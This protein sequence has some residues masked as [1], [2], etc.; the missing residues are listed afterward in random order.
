MIHS[1]L[2]YTAD[3]L[4]TWWISFDQQSGSGTIIQDSN[5]DLN[6]GGT[7]NIFATMVM[8]IQTQPAPITYKY[9]PYGGFLLQSVLYCSLRTVAAAVLVAP[10]TDYIEIDY[11]YAQ[12]SHL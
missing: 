12:R 11:S 2:C 7:L 3:P 4:N 1:I 8:A 5:W 10:T 9:F 6:G